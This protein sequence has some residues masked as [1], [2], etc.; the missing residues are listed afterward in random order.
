MIKGILE[1]GNFRLGDAISSLCMILGALFNPFRLYALT[2]KASNEAQTDGSDTSFARSLAVLPCLSLI[3]E[4][5]PRKR[6]DLTIFVLDVSF[7]V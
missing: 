4:F 3:E 6:S 7:A 2:S 1:R 5:A